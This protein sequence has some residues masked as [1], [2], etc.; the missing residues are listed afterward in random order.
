MAVVGDVNTCGINVYVEVFKP[1]TDVYD[2][3]PAIEFHAAPLLGQY[4]N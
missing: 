1:S 3:A 4:K 2:F